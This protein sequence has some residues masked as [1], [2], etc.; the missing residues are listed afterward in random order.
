MSSLVTTSPLRSPAFAAAPV[1]LTDAIFAPVGVLPLLLAS[2]TLTPSWACV[3]LPV[4]I[5]WSTIGRASS[6]GIAKPSADD[7]GLAAAA[8]A[9]LPLRLAIAELMPT[10]WPLAVD[11]GAAGVAGVDRG[12][13]LDR[14][15]DHR[16][17]AAAV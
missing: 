7:A 3:A 11:E 8:E 15:G 5:S 2:V 16:V 17:V 13:G 4:L 12:V 6:I 1:P 14:V 9:S 10:T